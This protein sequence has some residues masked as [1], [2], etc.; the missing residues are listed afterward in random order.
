M[1]F[2]STL[3]ALAFACAAVSCSDDVD[4]GLNNGNNGS[5]QNGE[6]AK[7]NVAINTETITRA[8]SHTGRGW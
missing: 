6:T 7:I 2:K 8:T 1:N 3:W 4:D 5:E